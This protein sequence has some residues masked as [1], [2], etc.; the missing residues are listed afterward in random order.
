MDNF[1]DYAFRYIL[2]DR[3]DGHFLKVKGVGE[4]SKKICGEKK[5]GGGQA[6]LP[7]DATCMALYLSK[8]K[9]QRGLFPKV[10]QLNFFKKKIKRKK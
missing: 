8:A 7:P 6:L 2:K 9:N 5:L 4:L 3:E 1:R 10:K